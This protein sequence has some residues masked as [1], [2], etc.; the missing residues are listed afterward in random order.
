[1]GGSDGRPGGAE[2]LLLVRARVMEF[3]RAEAVL[4]AV[5]GAGLG[6]G[7][8]LLAVEARRAP[9]GLGDAE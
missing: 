8:A 1:M 5:G 3:L 7:P 9:S 6:G 4:E 2:P